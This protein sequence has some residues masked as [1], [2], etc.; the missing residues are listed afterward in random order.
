MDSSIQP[1]Q[2]SPNNL[3]QVASGKKEEPSNLGNY[4]IA[5]VLA[6]IL[7]VLLYYAYDAFISNSGE[8]EGFV[9]G[10]RQE[11]DD[12]VVDFNLEDA[13]SA[14]ERKQSKILR[15][16]STDSGI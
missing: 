13:I 1:A 15:H 14:L 16:L 12:T 7:I 9:E 11:R 10:Q 5:G 3:L 4:I 2:V 8:E 6:L